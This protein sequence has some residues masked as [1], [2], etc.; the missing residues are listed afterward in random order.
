M[1][2]KFPFGIF[3]PEKQDYLFR[4]SVAP[5][6]CPQELSKTFCSI[7]FIQPD[8]LGTFCKWLNMQPM[9]PRNLVPTK[10]SVRTCACSCYRMWNASHPCYDLLTAV[11]I[12]YLLTS[13]TWLYRR[14][15]W[16]IHWGDVFY[17][18]FPLPGYGIQLIAGLKN[19]TSERHFFQ[20]SH[21][22]FAF[23]LAKSKS[24]SKSYDILLHLLHG[25]RSRHR[26]PGDNHTLDEL[27][28]STHSSLFSLWN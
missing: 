14:L 28:C 16:K 22:S 5:G 10:S 19:F 18:I 2:H 26:P 6:N 1:E 25:I 3:R 15:R 17:L 4:C 20:N 24:K 11:T 9:H 8:F 23:G 13:V 27:H 21:E 12:G 7:C